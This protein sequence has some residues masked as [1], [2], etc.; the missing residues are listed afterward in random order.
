MLEN[1]YNMGIFGMGMTYTSQKS[2]LD[3]IF[4]SK[5]ADGVLQE[6]LDKPYNMGIFGMG[7]TCTSQK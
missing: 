1:P 2:M 6:M 3:T 7:M 4:K 5:M